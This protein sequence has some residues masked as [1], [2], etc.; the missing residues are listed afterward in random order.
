VIAVCFPLSAWASFGGG[1]S[2]ALTGCRG[3][4]GGSKLDCSAGADPAVMRC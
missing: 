3:A 2:V 4:G 1:M